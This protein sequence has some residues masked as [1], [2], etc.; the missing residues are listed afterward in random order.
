MKKHGL[1]L[2][3]VILAL[4]LVA[5]VLS[6]ASIALKLGLDSWS[7][8]NEQTELAQNARMVTRRL[9]GELKY[10]QDIVSSGD[11]LIEFD[12]TNLVDSDSEVER[13]KYNLS[14]GTLY[15]SVW[16]M[17][18]EGGYGTAYEVASLINTFSTTF[19][20]TGTVAADG[21]VEVNIEL[22]NGGKTLTLRG[23]SHMR[24]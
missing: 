22:V 8:Q 21:L 11:N 23:K 15:R 19:P 13:I 16:N 4:A 10:A 3:E 14:A 1:T 6:S 7:F 18:T 24:N 17:D 20:A 12:T 2:V 9:L 5:L